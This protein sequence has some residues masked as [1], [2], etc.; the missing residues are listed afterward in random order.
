MSS[1]SRKILR[2]VLHQ[3]GTDEEPEEV[4]GSCVV[5]GSVVK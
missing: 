3:L 1:S 2:S 4:V 5:I